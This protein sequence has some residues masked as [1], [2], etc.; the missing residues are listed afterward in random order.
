[1]PPARFPL[2]KFLLTCSRFACILSQVTFL[3]LSG[4]VGGPLW[5]RIEVVI[6]RTTRNRL[7]GDEPVRGFESHRLRHKNSHTKRC[8]YFY[9]CRG[10]CKCAGQMKCPCAAPHSPGV[11]TVLMFQTG[12]RRSETCGGFSFCRVLLADSCT[13]L[14]R[15]CHG[16]YRSQARY[17]GRMFRTCSPSFSLQTRRAAVS[18]R[19]RAKIQQ[20]QDHPRVLTS[21][22][23]L[24]SSLS[25]NPGLTPA[26]SAS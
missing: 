15:P 21:S 20:G 10:K 23:L 4:A 12:N 18:P 1:M 2:E 17:P 24:I 25:C 16:C 3:P 7:I 6:T 11:Y 8:G 26:R 22:L 19:Q 14:T 13:I 9:G 5:R